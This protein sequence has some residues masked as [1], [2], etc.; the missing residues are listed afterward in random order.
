MRLNKHYFIGKGL[1]VVFFNYPTLLL[2]LVVVQSSVDSQALGGL[3]F[4]HVEGLR[5]TSLELHIVLF[6]VLQFLI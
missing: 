6:C 3:C 2:V 1:G 5:P 4:C